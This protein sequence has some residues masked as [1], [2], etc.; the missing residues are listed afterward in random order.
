MPYVTSGERRWVDSS[1]CEVAQA[2]RAT[3]VLPARKGL[4]NYV[5][6]RIVL[7]SMEPQDGWSYHSISNAVSVLR[8]AATEME[9]RLMAKREDEAIKQNGDLPEYE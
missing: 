8:D 2:I 6:S 5:I 3:A 1:L 4:V 9:R 7:R